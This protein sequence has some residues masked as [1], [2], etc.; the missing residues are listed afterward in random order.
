MARILNE[1]GAADAAI[2]LRRLLKLPDF[3][4]T[5]PYC[6]LCHNRGHPEIDGLGSPRR[7]S[8]VDVGHSDISYSVAKNVTDSAGV[9]SRAA[10]LGE[11]AIYG[12]LSHMRISS[13]ANALKCLGLREACSILRL[14]DTKKAA[15]ILVSL[16]PDE[17]SWK[18]VNLQ[19]FKLPTSIT[20]KLDLKAKQQRDAVLRDLHKYAPNRQHPWDYRRL[21]LYH[22]VGD[23][24]NA[25]IEQYDPSINQDRAVNVL[26][27][28]GRRDVASTEDDFH[29]RDPEITSDDR[30][31][32]LASM[33]N[34][35]RAAALMNSP[36]TAEMKACNKVFLR[37]VMEVASILVNIRL[38]DCEKSDYLVNEEVLEEKMFLLNFLETEM[39]GAVLLAQINSIHATVTEVEG[40]IASNEEE[41]IKEAQA[42]IGAHVDGIAG[43]IT[44]RESK[45]WIKMQKYEA[46]KLNKQVASIRSEHRIEHVSGRE[47]EEDVKD[48]A[49]WS[50]FMGLIYGEAGNDIQAI[51]TQSRSHS[52]ANLFEEHKP[53]PY[54]Q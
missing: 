2:L 11:Y 18:V 25:L 37:K 6:R 20:E 49:G 4:I 16:L 36:L 33:S 5:H 7:K 47:R 1:I 40:K 12:I 21:S 17:K 39:D 3:R 43:P 45:S 8:P 13:A 15:K 23:V 38:L 44:R 51:L 22:S 53:T 35:K 41:L 30:A 24:T 46:E 32:A 19:E 50:S 27:Y 48:H 26:K 28:L 14:A 31:V 29:S 42:T 9:T 54:Y 52:E 10:S 34:E